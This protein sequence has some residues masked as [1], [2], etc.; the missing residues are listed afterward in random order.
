MSRLSWEEESALSIHCL[1]P[2]CPGRLHTR[3]PTMLEATAA[4]MAGV[5]NGLSRATRSSIQS[6]HLSRG[7]K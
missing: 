2:G 4:S 1:I 6:I 3:T 7:L 5:G